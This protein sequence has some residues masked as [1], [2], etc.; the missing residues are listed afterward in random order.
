MPAVD[1]TAA[2]SPNSRCDGFVW[3]V[4]GPLWWRVL[5]HVCG[6]RRNVMLTNPDCAHCDAM[7]CRPPRS[8]RHPKRGECRA[9]L[10][11][12]AMPG[13]IVVPSFF[14]DPDSHG[15]RRVRENAAE[16]Y[17]CASSTITERTLVDEAA[18][19]GSPPARSLQILLSSVRSE[20]D[21]RNR[22]VEG[23]QPRVDLSLPFVEHSR[24]TQR[25]SSRF[26]G[27]RRFSEGHAHERRS[28]GG[29]GM[30]ISK[31]VDSSGIA[32]LHM[33]T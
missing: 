11:N 33:T 22:H 31:N 21:A 12:P 27:G 9:T 19:A 8:A 30:V 23:G 29:R 32:S 17:P 6:T 1:H 15:L 20:L 16:R 4:I 13:D 26:A 25:F 10:F 5:A 3:R 14:Y 28:C 2:D 24:A 7:H 18:S